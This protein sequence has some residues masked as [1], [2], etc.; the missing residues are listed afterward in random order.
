MKVGESMDKLLYRTRDGKG[1]D[2][3]KEIKIKEFPIIK[4]DFECPIC[5]KSQSQGS[6]I[7]KIVSS[8]FTDWGYFEGGDMICSE[9]SSR[10]LQ[11]FG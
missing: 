9:C 5:H 4:K 6:E 2:I 1:N 11:P 10:L 3:V 8:N 7:K